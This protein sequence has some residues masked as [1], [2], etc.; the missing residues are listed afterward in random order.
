ME[1]KAKESSG[2]RALKKVC[3][4]EEDPRDVKS[5]GLME[6]GGLLLFKSM[7]TN[8]MS[9]T[10]NEEDYESDEFDLNEGD[11]ITSVV[12]GMPDIRFFERVHTL[13]QRSMTKLMYKRYLLEA[14][15]NSIG[16]VA[17][18]DDN[19]E[20]GYQERFTRLAISVDLR[21]PLISK[22]RI[23]GQNKNSHSFKLVT[24][25]Y[26]KAHNSL[27]SEPSVMGDEEA[28]AA[29]L[30]AFMAQI[31]TRQQALKEQMA[32]FSFGPKDSKR[33][34]M[35]NNP[36]GELANLR[37][38]RIV[39]EYQHQFQSLLAKTANLKPRQQVNL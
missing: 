15:G 10:K 26:A 31:T 7:L 38:I 37:Q 39:E 34:P 18:M 19:I 36:L 5:H 1:Q 35:S 30:D 8:G 25:S 33:P 24:R 23:K 32:V 3:R 29:K 17:R 2:K 28:L 22:L 4:R 14:V 21:Q 27:V 12:D 6:A 11:I 16:Q 20:N 9:A 13:V